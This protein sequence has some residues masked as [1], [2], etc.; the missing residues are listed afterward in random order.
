MI[1]ECSGVGKRETGEEEKGTGVRMR[2]ARRKRQGKSQ[3]KRFHD[4]E[5]RDVRHDCCFAPG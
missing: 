3:Q 5:K 1:N 4:W 2:K